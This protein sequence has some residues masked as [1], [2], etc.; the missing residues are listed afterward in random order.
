[1]AGIRQVVAYW[2]R[3]ALLSNPRWGFRFL[4]DNR[5]AFRMQNPR[6]PLICVFL[7]QVVW[8]PEQMQVAS[9][10]AKKALPAFLAALNPAL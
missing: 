10:L 9:E 8:D 4:R 2:I 1:M 5:V 6:L 7:S 3:A